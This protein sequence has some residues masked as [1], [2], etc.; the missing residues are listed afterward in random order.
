[1]Q[2]AG[3][4]RAFECQVVFLARRQRVEFLHFQAEQVGQVV[5]KSG[6]GRD[7]VFV[8]QAGVERADERAAVLDVKFQPV[9]VAGGQQ[10]QRRREDDFV[11]RQILVRAR[12]IH[13]DI[14]V[15]QRGVDE[16]NVLAQAEK[17]VRRIG[18]LQ[19]PFVVVRVN[20]ARFGGDLGVLERGREDFQFL[21]DLRHFVEHAAAAFEVVR[22]QRRREISRSRTAAG[23]SGKTARRSRRGKQAGR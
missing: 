21:A 6:V 14:P 10:M 13:Q 7:A 4:K 17:F 5:R 11:F 19:R 18:L 8:H 15:V 12:E 23:A 9:G 3:G 20:D 22:Q 16:L 1:M 2:V